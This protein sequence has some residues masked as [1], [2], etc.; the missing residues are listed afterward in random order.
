M[1]F[2]TKFSMRNKTEK[3]YKTLHSLIPL[4]KEAEDSCLGSYF[5]VGI[6]TKTDWN[7]IINL[8]REQASFSIMYFTTTL[9][10]PNMPRS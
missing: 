5:S 2:V 10:A 4:L 7:Y 9:W 3:T 6:D 8:K 1:V